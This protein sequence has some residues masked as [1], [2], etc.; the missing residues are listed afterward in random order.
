M[1]GG[2][3][4]LQTA[5]NQTSRATPHP[6]SNGPCPNCGNNWI[7]LLPLEEALLRLPPG[8][9]DELRIVYEAAAVGVQALFAKDEAIGAALAQRHRTVA[10]VL[11]HSLAKHDHVVLRDTFFQ[12]MLK[13]LRARLHGAARPSMDRRKRERSEDIE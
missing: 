8:M 2:L 1:P 4:L 11:H 12:S 3:H 13:R 7:D 10:D 6:V 9:R 5:M